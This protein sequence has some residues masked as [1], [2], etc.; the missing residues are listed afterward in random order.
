MFRT[1]I[2]V[3]LITVVDCNYELYG[4]YYFIILRGSIKIKCQFLCLELL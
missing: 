1:I 4:E 3:L 2:C